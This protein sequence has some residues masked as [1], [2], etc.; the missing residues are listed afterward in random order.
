MK[1]IL[2]PILAIAFAC[3]LSCATKISTNDNTGS[4]SGHLQGSGD[5]KPVAGAVVL[6][7]NASGSIVRQAIADK[8]GDFSALLDPGVY[9]LDPQPLPNQKWPY[10]PGKSSVTIKAK[11]NV[12]NKIEYQSPLASR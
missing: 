9:T 6:I 8:N 5:A 3:L 7:E 10:P 4:L 12:Q 2:Y 11:E 1:K